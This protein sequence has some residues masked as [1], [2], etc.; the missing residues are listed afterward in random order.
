MLAWH[1]D[2][3]IEEIKG[4][5]HSD[6]GYIWLAGNGGLLRWNPSTNEQK[7]FS[8]DEGFPDDYFYTIYPDE[9]GFLWMPTNKGLIRF[10]STDFEV[11]IFLPSSGIT[12]EEF[13]LFSSYKDK[14]GHI[15]FGGLNGLTVF[16]PADFLELKLE[17]A[18]MKLTELKF[19]KNDS[20]E[21]ENGLT[22]FKS[23]N[24]VDWLPNM[25]SFQISFALQDYSLVN[26]Q[27]YAYMIEGLDSDWIYI[28]E[29]YLRF[30]QLPYGNY[31]LKIKGI[32]GGR[33]VVC[34][35]EYSS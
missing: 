12:H 14:K 27:S 10:N 34:S 33:F 15:Y 35:F 22:K 23:L 5:H 29:H 6:D 16:D 24:K 8:K 19:L 28:E 30:N 20:G 13:N 26:E 4:I 1:N 18:L 25:K 9:F 2:F 17:R 32:G 7:L 31:T 11:N 3:L 21:F